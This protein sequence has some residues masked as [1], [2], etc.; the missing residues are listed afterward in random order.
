MILCMSTPLLFVYV[1]NEWNAD[2]KTRQ[3]TKSTSYTLSV[4]LRFRFRYT[5]HK[6]IVY[7]AF[8]SWHTKRNWFAPTTPTHTYTHLYICWGTLVAY[9]CIFGSLFYTAQL[10]P[11]IYQW[12]ESRKTTL[13]GRHRVTKRHIHQMYDHLLLS[14]SI[15]IYIYVCTCVLDS[16]SGAESARYL[17]SHTANEP[18]TLISQDECRTKA[19]TRLI[20]HF[21]S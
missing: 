16:E 18:H 15:Y 10:Q 20:S 17:N 1:V 8:A 9:L 6:Q 21:H 5:K 19:K 7:M 12:M 3:R 14:T 13:Y 11:Q 2:K 4:R